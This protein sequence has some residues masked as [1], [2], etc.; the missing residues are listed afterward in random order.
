MRETDVYEHFA[1]GYNY[2]LLRNQQSGM[3]VRGPENSLES[4]IREF[5]GKLDALQLPVTT[6]ASESLVTLLDRL[7]KLPPAS[8]VDT[9]LASEVRGLISRVDPTLDAELQLCKAFVLTPRRVN[10]DHL[11]SSP[12][13]LLAPGVYQKLAEHVRFDF[14]GA[15][16]CIAFGLATAAAF[17]LM[18][19]LEGQLRAFYCSHVKRNRVAKMMWFDMVDHL[20]K[21]KGRARA[22]KALLD[23]LDNIR[24]NFRNPTQ[25]PDARY[26]I[27]AAQDLLFVCL[28]VLNRLTKE[29]PS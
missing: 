29:A 11:I 9:K 13:S 23:A 15:C 19:A 5:L 25:H 2:Y 24:V 12:A 8:T 16:R 22:S 21:S 27:E 6:V 3:L 20:R 4:R 17:H 28:D 18:R 10:L 7:K 14:R 26:D 1:F